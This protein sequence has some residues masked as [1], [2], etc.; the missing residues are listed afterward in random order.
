MYQDNVELQ[1]HKS[2]STRSLRKKALRILAN[3]PSHCFTSKQSVA[4]KVRAQRRQEAGVAHPNLLSCF[5]SIQGRQ[6]LQI[7]W[8]GL[9]GS[10]VP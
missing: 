4:P 9:P 2:I 6:L 7:S 5:I 10:Q 1:V 3:S 8:P